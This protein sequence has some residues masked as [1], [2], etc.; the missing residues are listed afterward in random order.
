MMTVS[1]TLTS[2]PTPGVKPVVTFKVKCCNATHRFVGWITNFI[3]NRK[4]PD[5]NMIRS[6]LTST[7]GRSVHP[8]RIA[9]IRERAV[10][11]GTKKPTKGFLSLSSDILNQE[12]KT[13]QG[14]GQIAFKLYS[15]NHRKPKYKKKDLRRMR[16]KVDSFVTQMDIDD[17]V[18]PKRVLCLTS[19]VS[20]NGKPWKAGTGCLFYQDDDA[21]GQRK[22]RVGKVIRYLVV[23]IDEEDECFFEIEEHKVL[24]WHRTIA[25]LDL[26]KRS[27]IRVTHSSHVVAMAAYAPYWQPQFTQ[28]KCACRVIDTY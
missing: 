18:A 3:H 1:K 28:Y 26:S 11:R 13:T 10:A 9:T 14:S 25:I 15:R 22:P 16:T 12:G 27:R 7:V 24:R 23:K 19:G 17:F 5:V 8:D 6:Y 20:F 4:D 21:R 2:S